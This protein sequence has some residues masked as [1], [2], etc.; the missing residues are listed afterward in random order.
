MCPS[1]VR[2]E[3]IQIL[4]SLLPGS[5]NFSTHVAR[6][7]SRCIIR[8]GE[9]SSSGD[10]SAVDQNQV[11]SDVIESAAEILQHVSSYQVNVRGDNGQISDVVGS[12]S[13]FRIIFNP[14]EVIASHGPRGE[15]FE[16]TIE[17]LDVLFGPLHF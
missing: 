16:S 2:M 11:T 15:D 17:L 12:L 14:N 8:D 13:F 3:R 6:L 7:V 9:S 5:I 1:F 4:D 10:V